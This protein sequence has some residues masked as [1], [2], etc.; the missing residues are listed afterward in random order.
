MRGL[1]VQLKELHGKSNQVPFSIKDIPPNGTTTLVSKAKAEVKMNG[2]RFRL[3]MVEKIIP[4]G[5]TCP[6]NKP[7]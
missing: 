5:T 4:K 2:Q 6:F 7:P 3:Y 1:K